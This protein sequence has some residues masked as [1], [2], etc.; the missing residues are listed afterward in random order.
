LF[1]V[2]RVLLPLLTMEKAGVLNATPSVP[3]PGMCRALAGSV[4]HTSSRAPE[5]ASALRV[6]TS[7]GGGNPVTWNM[8]MLAEKKSSLACVA[9]L[10]SSMRTPWMK[11]LTVGC[12]GTV[13]AAAHTWLERT[14]S[15]SDTSRADRYPD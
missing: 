5:G 6:S 13:A 12:G 3:G 15:R 7:D 11:W 8:Y 4:R 1:G 9:W 14:R 10:G 2:R